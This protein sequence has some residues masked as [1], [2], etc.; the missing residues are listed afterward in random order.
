MSTWQG[1]NSVSTGAS[2]Y[3]DYQED[4]LSAE[5]PVAVDSS[6]R[7][8]LSEI[9][10]S[11]IQQRIRADL[12]Q[13]IELGMDVVRMGE[14]SWSHVEPAEN[15]YFPDRFLFTLDECLQRGIRVIFCTPT[16][17]PPA[18]LLEKHP[19]IL[20][21]DFL[22]RT[23]GSGSRRQ[24]SFASK[25]YRQYAARITRYYAEQFGSHPA[26]AGFQI[27]NEFGCHGSVFQF[28]LETRQAFQDW[29]RRRYESIESLN[30]LWFLSFWSR[31]YNSFEQIG[32]PD[33]TYAD[34]NPHLELEFRRFSNSMVEE[35]QRA[36]VSI[37]REVTGK[38]VTHNFMSL[39]KDLDSWQLAAELDFAGFDHYQ[40]KPK[41]DCY[42]SH[43]QF[44]LMSSLRP[45]QPF[46]LLEQQPL[47]V[48][49]QPLNRR[50]HYDLLFQWSCMAA[51]QG[52]SHILYFSWQRFAGGA[53]RFHDAIVGH[54][55]L[56]KE[57]WQMRFL[58]SWDQFLQHASSRFDVPK[59]SSDLNTEPPQTTL[60]QAPTD[61]NRAR[62][63]F[64][65]D[66][67]SMWAHEICAQSNRFDLFEVLR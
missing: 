1:F 22:G 35:F 29:L 30:R 24:Y 2:Y 26:V 49:W 23:I 52:A 5:R 38:W 54:D 16:A 4:F 64:V 63:V 46:L 32:L 41:P 10:E 40:M 48:N 18:W 42:D 36:Q 53:E 12:D 50:L 20:P 21:R 55:G 65:F 15:Q 58:K 14:F 7:E 51:M 47:Q 39:F 57:T 27:D 25:V 62:A 67:S 11:Q 8:P 13:M 34:N 45:G 33:Y 28:G 66:Y 44:S 31:R 56:R 9:S 60:D 3:P 37:V 43:F 17:T 6:V 59:W 19:E 61:R